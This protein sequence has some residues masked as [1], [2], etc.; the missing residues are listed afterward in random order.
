MQ[1]ESLRSKALAAE[2]AAAAEDAAAAAEARERAAE[3]RADALQRELLETFREKERKQNAD[4]P[5]ESATSADHKREHAEDRDV[6]DRDV[7]AYGDDDFEEEER[8][9]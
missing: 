5:F 1:A 6:E 2:V 7:E 3:R 9:F 4:A 8:A